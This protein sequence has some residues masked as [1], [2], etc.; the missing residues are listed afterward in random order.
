MKLNLVKNGL[1]GT[2]VRW[3][4]LCLLA[5]SIRELP[6]LYQISMLVI[7]WDSQIPNWIYM[8]QQ[9][10]HMML[11]GTECQSLLP[12]SPYVLK[13]TVEALLHRWS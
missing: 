4:L 12:I 13:T 8:V 3:A 11:A 7:K 6:D 10:K 5:D 9:N 2:L 1:P